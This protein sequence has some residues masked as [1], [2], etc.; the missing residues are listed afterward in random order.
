MSEFPIP[1]VNKNDQ[2]D[3]W[4][5]GGPALCRSSSL[6]A[7]RLTG[8]SG[9]ARRRRFASL[10]RCLNWNER[11]LQKPIAGGYAELFASEDV[12]SCDDED[13]K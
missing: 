10:S 11:L 8:C 1:T 7:R 2:T 5:A 12:E 4:C 3:D 9:P 13:K 6:V